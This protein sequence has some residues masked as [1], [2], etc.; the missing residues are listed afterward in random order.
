MLRFKKTPSHHTQVLFAVVWD[1][2][3]AFK[4]KPLFILND[5]SSFPG[6]PVS[7]SPIIYHK[8]YFMFKKHIYTVADNELS[9]LF[10]P[11]SLL[12]FIE[13]EKFRMKDLLLVVF[14]FQPLEASCESLWLLTG[15]IT[16]CILHTHL[17]SGMRA[18][19]YP[20]FRSFKI[21]TF[22][23]SLLHS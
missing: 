9:G 13:R 23:L 6:W 3:K 22:S 10:V 8:E 4:W 16:A 14:L 18:I 17:S 19:S 15:S 1:G 5:Q 2:I 20:G 21:E 12:W 7:G 11:C